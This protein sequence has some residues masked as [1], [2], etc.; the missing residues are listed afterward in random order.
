[1][2]DIKPME[3]QNTKKDYVSFESVTL[4]TELVNTGQL[5][6]LRSVKSSPYPTYCF[7]KTKTVMDIAGEFITAH[8]L[9]SDRSV[10]ICWDELNKIFADKEKKPETVVTRNL[11]AVKQIISEGYGYMLKRTGVDQYKKKFFVF[12]VNDRIKDIKADYDA[13]NKAKY[14]EIHK[15]T[16]QK[17]DCDTQM[18]KLIMKAMEVQ[19]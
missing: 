15:K 7:E 18:S 16:T 2:E 19:K 12:Y 8:N 1:M 5:R 13:R 14:E 4:F 3:K 10:D 9:K 17:S 11:D 6:K